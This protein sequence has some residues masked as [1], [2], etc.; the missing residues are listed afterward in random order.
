MAKKARYAKKKP[1]KKRS[2]F[3]WGLLGF[4]ALNIVIII[5]AFSFLWGYLEEYEASRPRTAVE[6]YLVLLQQKDYPAA[7]SKASFEKNEFL[8]E[9]VMTRHI[10]RTLGEDLSHAIVT[11]VAGYENTDE[12]KCDIVV[13][14]K[15]LRVHL[16]NSGRKSR[17]NFPVWEMSLESPP[18][19]KL[20]VTAPAQA[21]IMM[22]GKELPE[23]F[24]KPETTPVAS[25]STLKNPALAPRTAFYE[26]NGLFEQPEITAT[27]D[28]VPAQVTTDGT[29][30]TVSATPPENT[31]NSYQKL[32]EDAAKV[33]AAFI[34]KDNSFT[35]YKKYLHTET[36]YYDEVKGFYNGWYSDHEKNGYENIKH[37]KT[38]SYGESAFTAE[39]SFD[40][41]IMRNGKKSVFPSSYVLSFLKKDGKML[42]VNLE[43][44]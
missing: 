15:K 28:G 14:R 10:E 27:L 35:G 18:S 19:Q 8:D 13:D 31:L 4:G 16:K 39:I 21:K 22:N 2:F 3:K 1:D 44:K 38:E 6:E 41:F 34:T 24:R 9:G 37:G 42:L 17:H 30:V 40:Y 20:T 36:T 26:V 23:R 12:R 5:A 29:T 32:A 25:F 43:V 7:F 11:E 33:Y